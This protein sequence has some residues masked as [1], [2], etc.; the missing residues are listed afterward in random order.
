MTKPAPAGVS[1]TI[2]INLPGRTLPAPAGVSVTLQAE[3]VVDDNGNLVHMPKDAK[4]RGLW[5]AGI[6]DELH[7]KK[8]DVAI[9]KV[10]LD[11]SKKVGKG[12]RVGG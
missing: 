1:V 11:P 10:V 2:K 3:Q 6:A 4:F 5:K 7:I 9:A 8:S 12:L